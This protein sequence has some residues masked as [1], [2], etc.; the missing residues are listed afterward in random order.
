MSAQ[1]QTADI[2][3]YDY[4]TDRVARSPVTL[5][6]LEKLK[7]TVDFTDEDRSY[8]TMVGK[9]LYDQAE[10]MVNAWREKIGAQPHLAIA[11][12]GPDGKPDDDCKSAVKPR[13][14]QWVVDLCTRPFD[15]AWLD[16]Q[17]EI[18]LRHVPEKRIRPMTLIRR[19]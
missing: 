10:K 15:Q 2:A 6:Q 12:S 19:Q 8:L 11:F 17:E 13:F 5:E 18:A 16:Y 1:T 3:G 14:V 9:V 7:E 4:V